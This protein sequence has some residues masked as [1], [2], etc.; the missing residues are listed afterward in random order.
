MKKFRERANEY[1][2][3]QKLEF[4]RQVIGTELEQAAITYGIE[5][6]WV[7]PMET[8]DAVRPE[9]LWQTVDMH[10][11]CRRI[12]NDILTED[13]GSREVRNAIKAEWFKHMTAIKSIASKMGDKLTHS[14]PPEGDV[15]TVTGVPVAMSK[16][17]SP[18]YGF[19]ID[20]RD[21]Y[22]D[23]EMAQALAAAVDARQPVTVAV[24]PARWW[25]ITEVNK[26]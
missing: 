16:N 13:N 20:G 23:T 18:I 24:S 22:A 5:S 9:K 15:Q 12:D 19:R 1:L 26:D 8:L 7:L 25:M 6:S 10:N 4:L 11:I 17:T 14:R 21:V 2:A 3:Q